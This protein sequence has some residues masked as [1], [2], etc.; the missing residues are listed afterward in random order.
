MRVVYG[1][2]VYLLCVQDIIQCFIIVQKRTKSGNDGAAHRH[3]LLGRNLA[4]ISQTDKL[5]P[6][7]SVSADKP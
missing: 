6:C 2:C 4:E 1:V 5:M 7:A 3:Q